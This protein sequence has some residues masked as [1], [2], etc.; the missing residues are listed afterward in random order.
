MLKLSIRIFLSK[1]QLFQHLPHLVITHLNLWA[2][3]TF[4]FIDILKKKKT[5]LDP[6]GEM[7]AFYLSLKYYK[8][9]IRCT[10]AI[11]QYKNKCF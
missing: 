6:K 10:S 4:F 8:I 1:C 11:F 5:I 7:R 3:L 9:F 2:A